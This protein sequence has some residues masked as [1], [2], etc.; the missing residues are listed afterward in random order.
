V[1]ATRARA[2]LTDTVEPQEE[3]EK[4]GDAEVDEVAEMFKGLYVMM[5]FCEAMLMVVGVRKKSP[6]N[7]K[8]MPRPLP[9]TESSIR[10]H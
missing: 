4:T 9:L 5:E 10:L 8:T 6:R 3:K 2:L 1:S 7:P